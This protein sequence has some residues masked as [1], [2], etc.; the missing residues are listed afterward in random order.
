MAV[1]RIF[2]VDTSDDLSFI[3]RPDIKFEHPNCEACFIEIECNTGAKNPIFGAL[4]RHPVKNVRLFTSYLGEFLENF[5]ARGVSLTIMG[6]I[7]IDLNKSNVISNEYINTMSSLGFSALINQPTRI[8]SYKGSNTVS[9]STLDHVITNSSSNFSKVGILI[10]DV[11]DHLPIF[12]SMSLSKTKNS[13]QNTYRRSF[14][15]SKEEK[16]VKCLEENLSDIDFNLNPNQIMDNI[17]LATKNAINQIFPI[18]KV[19]RKQAKLI[20]NPWITNEII[21]EGKLRDKLQTKSVTSR[22]T[23]DYNKYKKREIK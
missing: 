9:C 5:A 17:L 3:K 6:D 1:L 12:A 19:S 22:N 4:Y 20:Q 8:Y 16:F 14:P 11:S 2:F 10:S 7:N 13:L 18:K 15:D 21:K 23:E